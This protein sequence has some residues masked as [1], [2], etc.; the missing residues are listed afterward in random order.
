MLTSTLQAQNLLDNPS[1][2]VETVLR[3]L[4][5]NWELREICVDDT[6]RQTSGYWGIETNHFKDKNYKEQRG[7]WRRFF[8]G[9]SPFTYQ[10]EVYRNSCPYFFGIQVIA[11]S[12]T[13]TKIFQFDR[14]GEGESIVLKLVVLHEKILVFEGIEDSYNGKKQKIRETYFLRKGII[15][16]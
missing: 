9:I 1:T 13:Q 2:N 5:N 6:C 12:L 8:E 14:I 4:H 16:N 7:I 3:I 10:K 15:N 11:D